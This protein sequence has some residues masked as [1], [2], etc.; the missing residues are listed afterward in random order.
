MCQ[1]L[2]QSS[3]ERASNNSFRKKKKKYSPLTSPL[4]VEIN[5]LNTSSADLSI[6]SQLDLLMRMEVNGR[7]Y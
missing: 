7:S 1:I 4:S 2:E 5:P 6:F 3:G